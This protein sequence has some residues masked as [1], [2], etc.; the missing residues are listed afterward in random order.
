MKGKLLLIRETG[1][2]VVISKTFKKRKCLTGTYPEAIFDLASNNKA[3]KQCRT[4]EGL[5]QV[6]SVCNNDWSSERVCKTGLS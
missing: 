6:K 3:K 4:E 5:L 1:F 2:T